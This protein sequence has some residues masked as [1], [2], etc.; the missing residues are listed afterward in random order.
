MKKSYLGIL[1]FN[2]AYLIIFGVYYWGIQNYEFL[3]YIGVIVVLG[4]VV[5]FNLHREIFDN[6]IL[7]LLS[8]WGLVHMIGGGVRIAGST[9][10]SLKLIEII[11]KSDQFY[12]LKM[13]QVIHFYGF[14]VSAILVYKLIIATGANIS[15][16]PKL[17]IFLSWIGSMGLGALNEVVEFLAFVSLDKTGVG[18]L[19]N[20]GL[21][22]IFNSIGALFGAFIAHKLYKN[23]KNKN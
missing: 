19:Y 16:S 7:W 9:V 14:L 5:A 11:N 8:V 12:V 15:K 20:T 4:I 13:D 21:D 17:M 2:L 22:L 10:Y 18:D 6:L 3:W 1:I 23:L